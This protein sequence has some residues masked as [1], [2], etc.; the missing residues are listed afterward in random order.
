MLQVVWDGSE[1]RT[2]AVVTPRATQRIV[3]VDREFFLDET[4]P[5][6]GYEILERTERQGSRPTFPFPRNRDR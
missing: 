3:N 6:A 4:K 2:R 1:G 5:K